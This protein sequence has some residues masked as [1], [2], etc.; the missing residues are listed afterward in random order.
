MRTLI[1]V[2]VSMLAVTGITITASQAAEPSQGMPVLSKFI[3]GT[4]ESVDP[5]TLNLT[6]LT[7][8]GKKEFLHV[9]DA[10]VLTGLAQG[11]RI[12]CEMDEK[13]MVKNILKTTP[14]PKGSPAPEP[15]G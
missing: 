6:I 14:D 9:A 3:G 8:V 1:L 12:S 13:G 4:I 10:S 2:L 15:K 5:S 11:D 7:D